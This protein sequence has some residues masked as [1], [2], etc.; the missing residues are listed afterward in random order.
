M[1]VRK[2]INTYTLSNVHEHQDYYYTNSHVQQTKKGGHTM[3]T[4]KNIALSHILS[5]IVGIKIIANR[6]LVQTY[7]T[8]VHAI[9]SLLALLVAILLHLTNNKKI[10]LRDINWKLATAHAVIGCLLFRLVN[11]VALSVGDSSTISMAEQ[12]LTLQA[13]L[14]VA[15]TQRKMSR[16]QI[17]QIAIL[18]FSVFMLILHY[19]ISP[20]QLTALI[21]CMASMSVD[22]VDSKMC[23]KFYN[24]SSNNT[25][26]ISV[27]IGATVGFIPLVL[28][29]TEGTHGNFNLNDILPLS[30]FLIGFVAYA[31]VN[32]K[33]Y[34]RLVKE[35]DV[36]LPES[37]RYMI[38][39]ICFT[40]DYFTQ[41]IIP[42]PMLLLAVATSIIGNSY[43]KLAKPKQGETKECIES[44]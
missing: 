35:G 21:V 14:L 33:I 34:I 27:L 40:Y 23:E 15:I 17:T 26:E 30:L 38:I 36:Y 4:K 41:N 39:V 42:T 43:N 11:N 5:I 10:R 1:I 29:G 9:I 2:G 18:L 7:G 24:K 37:A 6:N 19:R 31:I 20:A 16:T 3:Y 22:L 28:V 13:L 32:N 12:T 44:V 25:D 8:K